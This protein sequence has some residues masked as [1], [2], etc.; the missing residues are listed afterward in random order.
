MGKSDQLYGPNNAKTANPSSTKPAAAV[1]AK[2]LAWTPQELERLGRESPSSIDPIPGVDQPDYTHTGN[3]NA[4]N[5]LV[6]G[7]REQGQV[8]GKLPS[9]FTCIDCDDW[10]WMSDRYQYLEPSGELF[11]DLCELCFTKRSGTSRQVSSEVTNI[12]P[13]DP[14]PMAAE[15]GIPPVSFYGHEPVPAVDIIKA[16]T[17]EQERH[18]DQLDAVSEA[19]R[20]NTPDTTDCRLDAGHPLHTQAYADVCTAVDREMALYSRV[21]RLQKHI[22]SLGGICLDDC[23]LCDD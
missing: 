17:D 14:K 19:S 9:R 13:P 1:R 10:C 5:P 11:E 6:T 23:E 18:H 16:I 4:A 15:G 2:D 12:D 3:N 8:S 20:I 21:K 7:P 22:H